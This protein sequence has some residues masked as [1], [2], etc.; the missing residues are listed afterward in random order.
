ME[1]FFNLIVTLGI[2]LGMCWLYGRMYFFILTTTGKEAGEIGDTKIVK[3]EWIMMAIGALVLGWL[4][5][6]FKY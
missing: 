4:A 3:E 1:E 2:F 6:T 5:G